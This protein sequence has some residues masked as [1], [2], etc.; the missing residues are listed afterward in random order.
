MR[1][2]IYPGAGGTRLA[3][4]PV[5]FTRRRTRPRSVA[6]TGDTAWMLTA[7][8]LV[9]FM[10]LPGARAVL[11]RPGAREERALGPDA[12]LRHHLRRVAAV[13]RGRL[14][15]AFGDGGAANGF[16]GG[17]DKAFLAGI[18]ARRR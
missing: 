10:T 14:P 12:V 6:N 2:S 1:A 8:A 9:L 11:R 5:I 3:A 7:T 16:I 18:D 13:A 17:F 4:V 15:L